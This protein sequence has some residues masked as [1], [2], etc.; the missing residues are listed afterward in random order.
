M[1]VRGTVLGA[2]WLLAYVIVPTPCDAGVGLS[3]Q[4]PI[5]WEVGSEV[6]LGAGGQMLPFCLLTTS[7][8][9]SKPETL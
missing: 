5:G 7:D 4:Y 3:V 9:V 8:L 1:P 6:M 2:L